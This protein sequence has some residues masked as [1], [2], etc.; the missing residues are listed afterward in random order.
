M[1]AIS[2]AAQAL[3]DTLRYLAPGFLY[4]VGLAP[5]L[6]EP[7]RCALEVLLE[8]PWRASRLAQNARRL[9]NGLQSLGLDTGSSEGHAIVPLILGSSARAAKWSHQ[10]L[11]AGVNVQPIL[12][13]AVPER[14]ARLRFFVS[15]EHQPGQI[16]HTLA[17]LRRLTNTG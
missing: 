1:E 3:V 4:S 12:H 2:P 6:A 13:P 10:L 8:E 15:C 5:Q 9:F 17:A 7:A 11:R 16:D 14:S